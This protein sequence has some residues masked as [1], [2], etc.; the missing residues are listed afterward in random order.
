M[1]QYNQK[2]ILVVGAMR[3]GKSFYT[4]Q[5]AQRYNAAGWGVMVYNLG[6]PTDFSC[7]KECFLVGKEKT[8][9]I[10]G[11]YN[12]DAKKAFLNDP[13]LYFYEDA[14]TGKLRKLKNF[15]L[16][17]KQGGGVGQP[18]KFPP[19]DTESERLFFEAF[20]KY[21]S[22]TLLILDDMRSAFRHGLKAE[23]LQLF[24]RINHVGRDS[25]APNWRAKGASVAVILH[26]LEDV[27]PDIFTYV[28]DIDSFKYAF[29]P[30][31]RQIQNPIIRV[32]L[33]KSFN[34][35]QTAPQYSRTR[36][37]VIEGVTTAY[38]HN[39]KPFIL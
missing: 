4:N 13:F 12:K 35:L 1:K 32:E 29:A 10:I 26:S 31:F 9:A 24:S 16:P 14:D 25:A 18:V 34:W 28:T 38:P 36:T 27:N 19:T 7:A 11:K 6:R 2:L 30:D 23:V 20:Y 33:E 22:N 17:A 37:N 8:A 3:S 15:T 39:S 21:C 5:M